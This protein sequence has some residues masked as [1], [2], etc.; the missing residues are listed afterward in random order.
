M[1]STQSSGHAQ[2]AE[3]VVSLSKKLKC[4][5]KMLTF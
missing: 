5:D 2:K 4:S 1:D 3:V